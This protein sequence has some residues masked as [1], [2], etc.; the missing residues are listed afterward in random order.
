MSDVTPLKPPPVIHC[1][2]DSHC[3]FF[4]GRDKISPGFPHEQ[5]AYPFFVVHPVGPALAYNLCQTGTTTRGREVLWDRLATCVKPGEWVLLSFGEIDCRAHLLLQA[6]KQQRP[7]E[8]LIT[9]CV[10]RYFSVVREI[11]AMGHRVI[12]YNVTPATNKAASYKPGRQQHYPTYGTPQQRNAVT[13]RFNTELKSR[14][15]REGIL[16]LANFESLVDANGRSRGQFFFDE[17]H[18]SQKAMPVTL[19]ALRALFP[20]H[21]FPEPAEVRQRESRLHQ[22]MSLIRRKFLNLV[23]Y[24]HPQHVGALLRGVPSAE[25]KKLRRALRPQPAPYE[26]KQQIIRTYGTRFGCRTMIETGTWRGDT[27]ASMQ[28]QFARL[29]SIELSPELHRAAVE[30]FKDRPYITIH[31]GDSAEVLPRVLK[32]IQEPVLFWLDG[33]SSG[34][35]TAKGNIESPILAELETILRHPVKTHA[36]L[37]DDA[38]EFGR[39][40][41]YPT[42]SRIE[43]LVR[44]VYP[45]FEVEDDIIRITPAAPKP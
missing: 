32:D 42:L 33:H 38:R 35:E 1:L 21:D 30:R 14:C 17:I 12:V 2:G 44:S 20:G 23:E 8:Q 24:L 37:I 10:E 45:N 11:V 40:K 9:D 41:G 4:I 28:D 43:N 5:S 18:L 39:G 22:A 25:R 31:Q 13:R 34:G 16:F 3:C 7:V 29:H 27:I 19:A 6:E 26:V 15:D 36:I